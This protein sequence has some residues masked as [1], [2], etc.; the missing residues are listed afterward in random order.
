MTPE[1]YWLQVNERA[2]HHIGY[3]Q[4]L[5]P[6]SDYPYQMHQFVGGQ[7]PSVEVKTTAEIVAEFNR[8]TSQRGLTFGPWHDN[9]SHP[10]AAG[11]T[12]L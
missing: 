6:H 8:L 7:A 3:A 11:S 2:G 1:Q 4:A 10:D 9:W 12:G 5:N